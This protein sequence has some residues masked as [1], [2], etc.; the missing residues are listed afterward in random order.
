MFS[1]AT[2]QADGLPLP[3]MSPVPKR[4]ANGKDVGPFIF[5]VENE[6]WQE[7]LDRDR[8]ASANRHVTS[9]VSDGYRSQSMNLELKRLEKERFH[10][11]YLLA[12]AESIGDYE[13][14]KKSREKV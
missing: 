6:R 12:K 14:A 11:E 10:N 2:I 8:A 3:F 1:R 5:A 13:N 9:H 7:Q 4:D